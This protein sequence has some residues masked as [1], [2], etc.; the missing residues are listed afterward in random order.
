MAVS[1][2]GLTVKTFNDEYVKFLELAIQYGKPFL[3]ENL[4]EELDPMV[5]PVL[6]KK[7]VIVNGQKMITLGPGACKWLEIA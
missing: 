5:D 7:V 1:Q 2:A 4:D 6:E 3:F